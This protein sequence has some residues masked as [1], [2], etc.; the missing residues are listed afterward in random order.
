MKS[1]AKLYSSL[2]STNKTNEKV[3]HLT[4]F[5]K[6]A[7][8]SD[9]IH[10]IALFL[11]KRPKRPFKTSMLRE[12]AAE[13]S[14]IPNWLFEE[15]YHIVGDLAET[16][17]LLVDKSANLKSNGKGLNFYINEINKLRELELGD[18]KSKIFS[19]WDELDSQEIFVFNK[20]LTGGLRVG[21]S[22]NLL[23][24]SLA[25]YLSK[26]QSEI[27]HR[28]MGDWKPEDIT[29]NELFKSKNLQA[30]NSK[31]YPFHLAY[32]VE[33]NV[34]DLGNLDDWLVEEKW[35]GIRGQII[36]RNNELY[37]WSRGEELITDK[38]PEFQFYKSLL[39][40]NIVLDGEILANDDENILPFQLLQKRITRKTL[41]KKLLQDIKATFMVYDIMEYEGKDIRDMP[42]IERKTIINDILKKSLAHNYGLCESKILKVDSW[43]LVT[44]IRENA[45]D[46]HKEGLMIKMKSS[47]YQTGRKKGSWWKWKAEPYLVDAVLTYAMRGHGRRSNLY[48]DYTFAVWDG[49]KL[50]TFAKA[51]SGLSNAELV[52]V[53]KFI[54]DNTIESF[55]P[56]RQVKAE[57]VFEIAFEGINESKRHKSGFAV[58]F[59]RISK[60][61]RDKKAMEANDM[62]YLNSLLK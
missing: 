51:Y 33:G 25:N 8:E 20:V 15:T 18:V 9:K 53:D 1:F 17:A 30:D 23:S 56:V 7:S 13:Y 61:R 10:S 57:L 45:R 54:K 41:T 38:F 3:V 40:N 31:P 59:P 36:Y 32:P 19:F 22:Q 50:V 24:K 16:I 27:A 42:L 58:R 4:N 37:V 21:V 44:K 34:R 11:G 60:W 35:D 48:S 43:D 12:W 47:T 62:K 6:V 28:L 5:L 52:E 14:N 49:D 46:Y 29:F 26:D 55:G 39:P 2:D